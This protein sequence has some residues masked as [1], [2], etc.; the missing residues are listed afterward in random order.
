MTSLPPVTVRCSRPYQVRFVELLEVTR[1]ME[2]LFG[3]L[4]D[5]NV[6]ELWPKAFASTRVIHVVPSGEQSKS[7]EQFEACTRALAV[8]GCQRGSRIG[9]VGGGVAGDLGGFVASTYMRGIASVQVPTTLL[10]MVD[11]SVGGKTALDIPEGKNLIG[12]FNQPD[13]VLVCVEFLG[14]L[15]PAQLRSGLAEVIKMGF[16]VEP[17]ILNLLSEPVPTEMLIR[18]SIE[19]KARVVAEDEFDT[20]GRRAVL[21]FGHTLGHAIEAESNFEILHGE[22]ISIGMLLEA[23]LGEAL[24]VTEPGLSATVRRHLELVGLPTALPSG[25]GA[26]RLLR[27]MSADKKSDAAGLGFSLVARP[28]ECKLYPG[29]PA[30]KVRAVVDEVA[31]SSS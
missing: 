9:I 24:G 23:R 2:G 20:S 27:W 28:G 7:V 18:A 6:L 16:A 13:D 15:P 10:S 30:S 21:N 31:Q 11:S 3:V 14:T 5:A 17:G 29:V 26:D 1:A 8:A 12:S 4:V 25:M 19:A 22:A